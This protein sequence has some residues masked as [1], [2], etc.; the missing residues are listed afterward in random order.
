MNDFIDTK[1]L[2]PDEMVEMAQ[3]MRERAAGADRRREESFQRCDTDGFLT[4]W[5]HGKMSTL[6]HRKMQILENGGKAEFP[7]LY[8]GDRRVKAKML[9][10]DYGYYWLLHESEKDLIAQRGKPFLPTGSNSRVQKRLGLSERK[11]MDWAWAR[12]EGRGTG[13]SGTCWAATYRTGD[14]WGQDAEPVTE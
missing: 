11:E 7:G 9:E 13:L 14:E 10:G 4:Q 1:T 5:A 2:T 3:E 8:E 12:M 6:A